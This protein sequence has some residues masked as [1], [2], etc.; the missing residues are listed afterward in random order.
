MNV[1]PQTAKLAG[2]VRTLKPEIRKLVKERMK[3]ICDGLA[4]MHGAKVELHY[5][6]GYPVTVNHAA[7]TAFAAGVA[8][9]IAGEGAVDV[10][11]PPTMGGEDFAYMLEARPGA[12]IFIGNGDTA[13]VHHPA[14]DFN[15]AAIPAGVS[16]WAR[17]VE[18]AMP[19]R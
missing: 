4:L 2:T 19:A 9:Q 17:L 18:T 7:Q 3:A 5:A 6:D 13:G 11:V 15:D 8:R 10:D 14:Y 16:Y 12:F 1:I